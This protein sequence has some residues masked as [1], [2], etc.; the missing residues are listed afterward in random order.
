MYKKMT[1][2]NACYYDPAGMSWYKI[3]NIQISDGV[4][5]S[6]SSQKIENSKPTGFTYFLIPGFI[7]AHCHLLENPYYANDLTFDPPVCTQDL[8]SC[9]RRNLVDAIRCGITTLKDMGG[10]SFL[11]IDIA[12]IFK[13]QKLPQVFTSGCYFTSV[14][15]HCSDR[16]A[17]IIDSIDEFV[18]RVNYLCSRGIKYCKIIH[19]DDGFE[20]DLLA[21]MI[22]YAHSRDMLVSCHAYTEKA[23][24]EAVLTGT[25]TLEHA[26]DYSDS[27]LDD[28]LARNVIV[29]PTYVA[30]KDSTVENC[31][32]LNDVCAQVIQQWYDGEVSVIPKLFEKNIL[33]ALGSDSGF[34]G[35]P[36]SSI[37]REIIYL[38]QDFRIPIEKVLFSAYINTPKTLGLGEKLGRIAP[39]YYA[40]FSCYNENPFENLQILGIPKEVWVR[41]IIAM[42]NYEETA[43]IRVLEVR[44]I[45]IIQSYINDIS[46]DCAGLED[47]WHYDELLAWIN[48][49][50]DY[51]IGAFFREQLV[52]FCLTHYHQEAHK[53]HIENIYT[54]DSFRNKGIANLLINDII[55]HYSTSIPFVRFVALV[56]SNNYASA[57]LLL[58]NSFISGK[59][60]TWIQRNINKND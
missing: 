13:N 38:A 37:I 7:D 30:A 48:N 2:R 12:S 41:G 58:K 60:M 14:G 45:P 23:A 55:T 47:F 35:T 26:G 18:I 40:N 36:C 57:R 49:S 5:T 15:G 31:E 24:H 3:Y 19:G 54:L 22:H 6:L 9:A 4:I 34:L 51:C 46:F 17:I 59:R 42:G 52:G 8:L 27:L 25:D 10:R 44:D 53:V 33:V 21:E 43:T 11:S 39:G 28:I 20:K 32:I 50:S 1:F 16:G 56:D 29:V